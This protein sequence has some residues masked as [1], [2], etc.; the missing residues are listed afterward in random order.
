MARRTYLIE[1]NSLVF[2]VYRYLTRYR[3]KYYP[4]LD[5]DHKAQIDSMIGECQAFLLLFPKPDVEPDV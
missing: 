5:S 3:D 1:M 4:G 2:K